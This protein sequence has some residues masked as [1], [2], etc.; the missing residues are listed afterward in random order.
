MSPDYRK[1]LPTAVVHVLPRDP[2]VES[3]ALNKVAIIEA[4]FLKHAKS[5]FLANIRRR[6][7]IDNK[8]RPKPRPCVRS[9]QPLDFRHFHSLSG[10]RP[11]ERLGP[12]PF[13]FGGS[14][15]IKARN[16]CV[17]GFMA[18]SHSARPPRP[19]RDACAGNPPHVRSGDN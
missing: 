16:I 13:V 1:S 9:K 12:G 11:P 19:R 3:F 17:T 5:K 18:A 7:A 4:A 2:T 6:L 10:E 14:V 15:S 8:H